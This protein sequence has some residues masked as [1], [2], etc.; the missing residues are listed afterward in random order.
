[1]N[2]GNKCEEHSLD[3][4]MRLEAIQK[5]VLWVEESF[6]GNKLVFDRDVLAFEPASHACGA[7]IRNV[8]GNDDDDNDTQ[9]ESNMI[10][11]FAK[12]DI[13]ELDNKVLLTLPYNASLYCSHP[14]V[15]K[16][17]SVLSVMQTVMKLHGG[18]VER[19]VAE[20]ATAKYDMYP[21]LNKGQ[22]IGDGGVRL[23]ILLTLM[24]AV[25]EMMET[26][27]CDGDD[28]ASGMD[29]ALQDELEQLTQ[30][31]S[32]YLDT[33]P[34][35]VSNLPSFWSEEEIANLQGTS[36]LRC[37]EKLRSEIQRNWKESFEPVLTEAGVCTKSLCQDNGVR[38]L[39]MFYQKAVAVVQ[40]RTHGSNNKESEG[41]SF[42][43]MFDVMLQVTTQT[44]DCPAN[45][46]D[47]ALHP[48]LDLFNGERDE[49]YINV[50]L[51]GFSDPDRLELRAERDIKAGEELIVSYDVAPNLSYLQNFGFVPLNQGE[52][53]L[54]FDILFLPVP[55]H[56]LPDTDETRRWEL[57]HRWGLRKENLTSQEYGAENF[58][59]FGI[60]NMIRDYR[61]RP[62]N[63]AQHKATN[64]HHI[65]RILNLCLIQKQYPSLENWEVEKL[66][67][68]IFDYWLSQ[69]PTPT[70]E[71]DLKLIASQTGNLR[72]GTSMRM[73]ER[74]I[75]VKWRHATC[76]R[77]HFYDYEVEYMDAKVDHVPPMRS[78]CCLTCKATFR[79]KLCTRCRLVYYC[80]VQC[81][82]EHWRQGHKDAC[83]K[84]LPFTRT[85]RRP[86]PV[87]EVNP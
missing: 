60:D 62:K 78:M 37:I 41:D 9:T 69:F 21:S 22:I 56:L 31:W 68:K 45:C 87:Y 25:K 26:K 12:Q 49:R 80:G 30:K 81:Q 33:L 63:L 35:D 19:A 5:C 38:E 16:S 59:L 17:P 3:I 27:N 8:G 71:H 77:N 85:S 28:L 24:L 48:L 73:L 82:I 4:T 10:G 86:K 13:K 18:L 79:L 1:M 70:N 36:F 52:P 61:Q 34:V 72:L 76:I 2:N 44:K 83:G 53:E 64:V 20:S 43:A 58:I 42:L 15:Q 57:M 50:S 39:P 7:V 29:S 32:P 54:S 11:V 47:L 66:S 74:E 40:S 67:T 6:H 65:E 46:M 55:S 51:R 84:V 75:I 14:S 23:T